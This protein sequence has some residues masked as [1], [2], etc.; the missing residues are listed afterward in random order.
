M[1]TTV[2]K[3]PH[4]P[5]IFRIHCRSPLRARLRR[6]PREFGSPHRGMH[7]SDVRGCRT[8]GLKGWFVIRGAQGL[9]V[10]CVNKREVE[11]GGRREGSTFLGVW[12]AD[13]SM[14]EA[15]GRFM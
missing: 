6:T 4:S 2:A 1:F 14:V 11:C 10:A 15:A 3:N 9:S 12:G 5:P 13:V 7:V 8:V